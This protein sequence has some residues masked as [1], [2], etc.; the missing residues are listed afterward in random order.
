MS[1]WKEFARVYALREESRTRLNVLLAP[2]VLPLD[3]LVP[4]LPLIDSLDLTFVTLV[5]VVNQPMDLSRWMSFCDLRNLRALLVDTGRQPTRFDDR[6]ARGWATRAL[7]NDQFQQLY[8]FSLCSY[9]SPQV[10]TKQTMRLLRDI[11]NLHVVCLRGVK[12][13]RSVTEDD[14]SGWNRQRYVC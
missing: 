14:D 11:P 7:E 9:Y 8:S 6:A 5:N 1:V 10:V 4:T 13:S 2:T 3:L 12:A